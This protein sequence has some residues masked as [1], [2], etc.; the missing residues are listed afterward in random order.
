M[1]IYLVV[2]GSAVAGVVALVLVSKRWGTN[3]ALKDVA[4][5]IA[6]ERA[7]DAKIASGSFVDDP[8]DRM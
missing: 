1:W 2:F 4:V 3:K 7:K 6:K 8:L 5:K